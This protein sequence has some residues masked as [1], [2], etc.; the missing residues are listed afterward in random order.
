MRIGL[1]IGG[2]GSGLRVSIAIENEPGFPMI[3]HDLT[4]LTGSQAGLHY[5]F[6]AQYK[7]GSARIAIVAEDLAT[8]IWGGAVQI[9]PR[10]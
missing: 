1:P 6:P 9:L 8:A 7:G 2:P 10:P 4:A 5:T 3:R